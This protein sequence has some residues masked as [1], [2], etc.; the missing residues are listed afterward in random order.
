MSERGS[1]SKAVRLGRPPSGQDAEPTIDSYTL[2]PLRLE[3]A[4]ELI[5]MA[6]AARARAVGALGL[7]EAQEHSPSPKADVDFQDSKREC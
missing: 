2:A 7:A 4:R 1:I 6:R 3:S 5:A